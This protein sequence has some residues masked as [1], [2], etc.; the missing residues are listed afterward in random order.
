[1]AGKLDV[2]VRGGQVVTSTDVLD[3]AVG[4]K[5]E[6][7]V[8]LDDH[9]KKETLPQSI[10]TMTEETERTSVLDFGFHYILSNTP[11][12]L[13]GIPEAIE[14]GVSSFKLFMTYKKRPPRMCSDD[15][16]CK[17]MEII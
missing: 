5:G 13:D 10:K 16:I 1:M 12:I 7:I 14:M 8:A 6:K 3:V 15:F 9:N 4:I 17:A 11:Y 2:V